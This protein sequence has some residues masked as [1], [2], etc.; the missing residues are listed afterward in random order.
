M[1][2]QQREQIAKHV[3]PSRAWMVETDLFIAW[4][5][6]EQSMRLSQELRRGSVPH[7]VFRWDGYSLVPYSEFP[8]RA[9]AV[10]T[11]QGDYRR[12]FNPD[13]AVDW[14]GLLILL[15]VISAIAAAIAIIW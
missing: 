15:A 6:L 7:S 1:T 9:A 8:C 5:G 14:I 2:E 4:G 13:P 3:D 10:V 12:D 11:G